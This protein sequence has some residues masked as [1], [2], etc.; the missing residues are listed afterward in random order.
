MSWGSNTVPFESKVQSLN[1]ELYVV[2][3]NLRGLL[4]KL[5][6]WG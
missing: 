2:E 4:A 1:H 3:K 6:V 5:A